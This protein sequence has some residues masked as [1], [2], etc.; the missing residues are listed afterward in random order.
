MHIKDIYYLFFVT[1]V[2][3]V[4][5]LVNS[6]K[7]RGFKIESN[8]KPELSDSEKYSSEEY[9]SET[10][11]SEDY[12]SDEMFNAKRLYAILGNA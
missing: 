6:G 9:G 12:S 7:I 1:V 5:K 2:K 3:F 4:K 11:V 8:G 10:Y